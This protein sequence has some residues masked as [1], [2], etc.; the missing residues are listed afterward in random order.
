[1]IDADKVKSDFDKVTE[2]HEMTINIDQG[3][4]R[5]I[6]FRNPKC[7]EGHYTLTTWFN[8]LC[9]SGDY[10]TFVFQ[11]TDD[12][13]K[14]FRGKNIN[15]SYWGEKLQSE[16][17]WGGYKE[18]S[19]DLFKEN[20]VDYAEQQL[21]DLEYHD[22]ELQAHV[23]SRRSEIMASLKESVLDRSGEGA[24]HDYDLVMDFEN[25]HLDFTDF[26]EFD[27]LEYTYQY[28]WCLYAI[29]EG[30]KIYDEFKTQSTVT[31]DGV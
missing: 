2:N 26:W 14:F 19:H 21:E 13:F 24:T 9:I 27:H 10:G 4:N 18:Y 31:H 11:R 12:M 15:P 7:F 3:H 29:V 25:D 5:S 23:K 30:I 1:M 6:L 17:R 8:H 16:S 28:I 22:D 20:V